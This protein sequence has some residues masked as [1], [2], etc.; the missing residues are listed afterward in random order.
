M[1]LHKVEPTPQSEIDEGDRAIRRVHSADDVQVGRESERL[2]IILQV[3]LLVAVLQQ[4]IKFAEH[5]GDVTAVD[6]INDEVVVGIRV[7]P[8]LLCC[9]Q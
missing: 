1:K 4:E 8:R 3:D 5:I 7:L 9:P 2:V 6:L